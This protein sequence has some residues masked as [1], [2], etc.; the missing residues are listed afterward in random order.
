M[1]AL[2]K[3]DPLFVEGTFLGFLFDA[4]SIV[5]IDA[6]MFPMLCEAIGWVRN[7]VQPIEGD[8]SVDADEDELDAG[9]MR[10]AA[11]APDSQLI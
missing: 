5:G 6:M 8:R 2:Q 7:F 1:V 4:I 3:D 10:A 11:L 9:H